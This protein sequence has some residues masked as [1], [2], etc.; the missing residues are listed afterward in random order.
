VSFNSGRLRRGLGASMEGWVQAG[1][2]LIEILIDDTIMCQSVKVLIV[3]ISVYSS[4]VFLVWLTFF[5]V[6]IFNMFHL[7]LI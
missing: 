3:F 7:C 6:A 2:L 4:V 5:C 1:Y